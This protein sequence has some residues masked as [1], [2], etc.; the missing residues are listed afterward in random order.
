MDVSLR[1]RWIAGLSERKP[2][3]GLCGG[4]GAGKSRVAAEFDRLG[5]VVI[6]SDRL[7]HEV[8]EQPQVLAELV[9]WWGGDVCGPDGKPDRKRIA[10]IVFS[11]AQQKGRLERLVYP[12]IDQRR[13]AKIH[14]V[15]DQPAVKAIV[16]D[17][18]LLLESNLDRECDA[19]VFVDADQSTRIERL[20]RTRGW[21]AEEMRRREGHH[22][23]PNEKCSRA[24]FI[25]DNNGSL[26]QLRLQVADILQKI[27]TRHF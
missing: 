22:M 15:Q 13:R 3:I 19:I 16:I 9:R 23:P 2:I 5:C 17:S 8:L 27:V 6:D 18:P 26:E 4:I 1:D 14:A 21:T 12:L 24:D 10:E 25:L 7:N 11:D 20:R